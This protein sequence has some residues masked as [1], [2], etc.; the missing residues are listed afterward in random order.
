MDEE[1]YREAV[2]YMWVALR[3]L[4]DKDAGT[5]QI[6]WENAH[7]AVQEVIGTP[8]LEPLAPG[9]RPTVFA[10]VAEAMARELKEYANDVEEDG[11]TFSGVTVK[12]TR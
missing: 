3:A 1:L 10:I 9:A 11:L 5:A 4:W 8:S 2:T 6:E 7:R 12:I